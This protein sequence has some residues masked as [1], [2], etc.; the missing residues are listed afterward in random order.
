[1]LNIRASGRL[2]KLFFPQAQAE[3]TGGNDAEIALLKQQLRL[4]EQKLDHL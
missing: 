2:P 4:M 3:S 1:L